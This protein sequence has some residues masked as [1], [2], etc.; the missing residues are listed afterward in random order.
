MADSYWSRLTM[1]SK[2]VRPLFLA[3]MLA[4]TLAVSLNQLTH[5]APPFP[6]QRQAAAAAA[7]WLVETHQNEDGGYT[8]FSS[9]ANNAPSAVPGTCDA[10]IALSSAG[11]NPAATYPSKTSNPVQW[12]ATHPLSVALYAATNGG[13]ASKVLLA[14]SAAN[15]NPR[16]FTGY[17]WV[18]SL[19]NHYKSN[20]QYG[21]NAYEQALAIMALKASASP[22]PVTA[23]QWLIDKQNPDTGAWYFSFGIDDL[24]ATTMSLMG[25]AAA[26]V[27]SNDPIIMKGLDFVR[28]KQ[29]ATTGGWI[30]FGT[31]VSGSSTTLA[32]Q[33]L[34]AFGQDFY[35]PN[36]V[37]AKNG[38]TPLSALLELQHN[39]GAFQA[40]YDDGNGPFPD[41]YETTQGMA[42][43]MGKPYPLANRYQAAKRGLSCLAQQQ[44]ANGGFPAFGSLT[45]TNVA[46][47]NGT[48]RAIQTIVDFG[49]NPTAPQWT[50]TGG[51]PLQ[52]LEALAPAYLAKKEGGQLGIVMQAVAKAA[53]QGAPYTVTNFAGRNLVTDLA[54]KLDKTTG[55]YDSTAFGTFKQAEAMLGLLESGQPVDPAAVAWLLDW[56]HDPV[57]LT[58]NNADD[59]GILLQVLAKVGIKA[60]TALS[61]A[62]AIQKTD[63]SWATIVAAN[64]SSEIAQGLVAQGLNPF[65]PTWSQVI[66]GQVVNVAEVLISQQQANGCWNN[67][68]A[69]ATTDMV[70]LLSQQP[71]WPS[72][73][74][75]VTATVGAGSSCGASDTLAALP[76]RQVTYCYTMQN[77]SPFT[78][79]RYSVTDSAWGNLVPPNSALELAPHAQTML[80]KTV[81]ITNNSRHIVYWR[82]SNPTMP[83]LSLFD[84]AMATVHYETNYLPLLL[85]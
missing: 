4:L 63:G 47:A 34:A 66:S 12:L 3:T 13:A 64:S 79:T 78:V 7:K 8:D 23:T 48:A 33:A 18:I 52:A 60:E 44:A 28:Q 69:F 77:N 55:E 61:H 9:G 82:A 54:Q 5:A 10:I 15:Q 29:D 20:G 25:L 80:S 83:N 51:N 17:N 40:D 71:A 85:K 57:N 43:A 65:D 41:F 38:K 76:G 27:P 39:N 45:G 68:D 24:D 14:V 21:R 11:N 6:D 2:F 53:R 49:E 84:G 36:G 70:S 74:L 19:T 81:T 58:E 50:K 62:Q 22:I 75:I 37:W 56:L 26:G 32:I 67:T 42:G 59:I 73:S 30:P 46:G 72:G 1:I 16:D 35:S 31:K